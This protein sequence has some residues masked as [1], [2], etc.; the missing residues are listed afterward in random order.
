MKNK[1]QNICEQAPFPYCNN[2][3]GCDSCPYSN[4]FP[5]GVEK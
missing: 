2:A 3:E 1:E 4:N 5:A